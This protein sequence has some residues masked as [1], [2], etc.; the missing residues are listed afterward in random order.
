MIEIKK[1]KPKENT[2]KENPI[3]KF[4]DALWAA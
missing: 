3:G 1:K 4:K 2:H